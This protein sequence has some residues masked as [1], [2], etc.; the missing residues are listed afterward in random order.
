V[1]RRFRFLRLKRR[2]RSRVAPTSASG[3]IVL[4]VMAALILC[5]LVMV[6][7]R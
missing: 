1:P 4:T 6:T 3:L 5:L 7:T 2:S